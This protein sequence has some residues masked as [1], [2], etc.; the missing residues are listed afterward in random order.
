MIKMLDL[1]EPF[2]PVIISFAMGMA[3]IVLVIDIGV[4]CK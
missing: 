3:V 4:I 1:V 2:Y